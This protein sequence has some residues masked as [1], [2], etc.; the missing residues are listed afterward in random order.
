MSAGSLICTVGA[1]IL[2]VAIHAQSRFVNQSVYCSILARWRRP[3]AAAQKD[4]HAH[5]K[6]QDQMP[7][8]WSWVCVVWWCGEVLTGHMVESLDTM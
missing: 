8:L 7:P 6:L 4:M 5:V 3:L 2:M 1:Y